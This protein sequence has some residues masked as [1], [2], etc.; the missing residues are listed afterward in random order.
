MP[1]IKYE[2]S[3]D[4]EPFERLLRATNARRLY[5]PVATPALDEAM[6]GV[7]PVG[8]WAWLDYLSVGDGVRVL[9]LRWILGKS[10]TP[11]DVRTC[12]AAAM[13]EIRR[14]AEERMAAPEAP[15]HPHPDNAPPP[16]AA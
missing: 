12:A 1:T 16:A 7:G 3:Y 8:E 6:A 10:D 14:V 5:P 4:R 9:W 15:A 11:D 13:N 2:F